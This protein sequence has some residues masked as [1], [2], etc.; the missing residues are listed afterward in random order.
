MPVL[1]GGG[2]GQGRGG[3]A[4]QRTGGSSPQTEGNVGTGVGGR[5]CQSVFFSSHP[6]RILHLNVVYHFSEEADVVESMFMR[7]S[8]EN[9]EGNGTPLQYSCPANPMDRGAW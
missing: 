9:R 4:P 5:E 2:Q 8:Y 6:S 7:P 3:E 1:P